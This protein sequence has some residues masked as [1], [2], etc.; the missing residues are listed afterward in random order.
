MGTPRVAITHASSLLAEAILEKLSEINLSSDLIVLL[1]DESHAGTRL[2]YADSYLKVQN[3]NE[4]DYSDCGL[5]LML[6]YD[7]LIEETLSNLDAILLSHTLQSDDQPVFAP[8]ADA[9]LNISYSQQ[10][11]RLA[12]ADLSCLLGVRSGPH[13]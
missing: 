13:Y 5:V 9:K 1:D 12:D 6:Q 3:Q 4:Y 10:S 8:N 11:I 7:Q 2:A